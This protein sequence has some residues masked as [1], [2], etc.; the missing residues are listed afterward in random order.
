ML[1]PM[2]KR[3]GILIGGAAA[4]YIAARL[5][6]V[7]DAC[8]WFDEIFS[9][10]AAEH[11]WSHLISFVA[12][13]LIHPPLFYL[14]LKLWIAAGGE[15]LL[16]LRLF[17]A[18]LAV[19]ALLPLWM[20]C[21]ELKLRPPTAALAIGLVAVNGA[22]IKYAQEVRMYSL[23]LLLSTVSIWLF[24]RFFFRGKSFWMLVLAN[25]LLVYS[26]YFGWFVVITE[27]LLIAWSQRIKLLRA[28]AM[29]GIT[30]AAFLPW[31]LTIW[32]YAEPGSSV[33]QNI[34]W[35]ARP[36]ISSVT[37]LV[38]DLVDPFYYQQSSDQPSANFLIAIPMLLI[39]ASAKGFW[40]F[41]RKD[42]VGRERTLFLAIFIAVPIVIVFVVSWMLPVS[43]WGSRHLLI[44]FVPMTVLAAIFL[45]EVRPAKVRY[46]F[47]AAAAVLVFAGF[48]MQIRTEPPRYIWCAWEPL[49]TEW[50]L[51][52]HN[53]SPPR[54][55]YV[56][57]DLV[58]YHYW[59]ATRTLPNY[60][61]T[62]IKGIEGVPNDPA[63]FLPRGFD[64]VQ[65]GDLDSVN[66][67]NIWVSFRKPTVSGRQG[68]GFLNDGYDR[69][70][71]VPVTSFEDRGYQ[72]EDVKKEVLGSQTAYLVRMKKSTP[73]EPD[74]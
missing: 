30:A 14:L 62:L 3:P 47:I 27:L 32:R 63:Y 66:E 59:F 25:I 21:R 39:I 1:I 58:A 10:H 20:L 52:P 12:K 56:F 69:L 4:I 67:E 15:S 51:T 11:P 35:M 24:S 6:R 31:V 71:E 53:S 60:E 23:L 45:T 57:E 9:V 70:F 22:L 33:E 5:W 18:T 37:E 55:L 41:D 8:L 13:D 28:S 44:V 2:L 16:W 72:V 65:T 19:L 64:E 74:R 50:I 54:H 29:F 34:G 48:G 68:E 73:A 7:T 17:P 38:L 26:H 49:A 40:L 43:I 42:K 36:G 46:G 61:V